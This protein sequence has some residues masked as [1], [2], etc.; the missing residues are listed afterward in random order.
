MFKRIL[1]ANRGE[2]ACRIIWACKE[3]GIETV[4]VFSEADHDA[5]HVQLADQAICIGP[6]LASQSYLSIPAVISAAEISNVDAI[7]PGY[8]FLAE[9]A[10]FA[11]V[12]EACQIKFIGPPSDL[13]RLMGDKA[14]ALSTM[15]SVG[16]P[17]LP[18][19]EGIVE[20]LEQ[21]QSVV[22]RIS[23]PV[24]IK[25][26]AGGGGRGIEMEE[27]NRVPALPAGR[28]QRDVPAQPLRLG[29]SVAAESDAGRPVGDHGHTILFERLAAVS[30]PG[31][32]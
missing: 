31:L 12:C 9:S 10:H 18:G 14:R 11:E 23:F 5:L 19:S 7:H 3:L 24:I 30:Q 29:L 6:S 32:A 13:I 4:T 15:K 21:A 22:R 20:T 28:H 2:I 1:I 27:A 8:G 17:T 16:V 25:A 26:V